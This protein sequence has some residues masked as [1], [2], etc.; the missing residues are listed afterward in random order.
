VRFEG[1]IDKIALLGGTGNL[2]RGLALRWCS[3]RKVI[4][5][6]RFRPKAEAATEEVRQLIREKRYADNI[7]GMLNREAAKEADLAVFCL[8]LGYALRLATRIR[9]VLKD[10]LVLCPIVSM[11][12]RGSLR[13]PR[14]KGSTSAAVK[15][16]KALGY[17]SNVVAG[18]HTVPAFM[19]YSS[20]PLH[21]YSVVIYGEQPAKG[22]VMRLVNEM[23]GLHSLDGGPLEMSFLSE[24]AT[25]LLLNLKKFN[26][27]RV[28]SVRYY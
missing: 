6:S 28:H 20:E 9:G 7:R 14:L 8:E 15:L 19:L 17:R 21:N 5:G 18:L 16:A 1:S 12:H 22:I 23:D 3:K 26:E 24:Y 27:S 2:G 11:G 13:I 10:K 4:I 25:P